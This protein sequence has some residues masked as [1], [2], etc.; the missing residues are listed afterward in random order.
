MISDAYA[1]FIEVVASVVVQTAARQLLARIRVRKMRESQL[2]ESQKQRN[3]EY[4]QPQSLSS[5][6]PTRQGKPPNADRDM[7]KLM[8]DLAAI[9]IQAA[10][11]GWWAR[12]CITVDN[13]CACIIQKN[14]RTHRCWE[15]YLLNCYRIVKVQSVVRRKLAHDRA[16]TLLYCIVVIQAAFRGYF[17]RKRMGPQRSRILSPDKA[18]T[19]I[20][21]QWRSFSSEMNFLRSYE[22]VLVVQSIARGWIT[23]RL[24]RS[25]LKA[26]NIQTSS[27]LLGQ[28]THLQR[29][30]SYS[31][32]LPRSFSNHTEFIR[33]RLPV[34]GRPPH[35]EEPAG[36]QKVGGAAADSTESTA[37]TENSSHQDGVTSRAARTF[38]ESRRREKELAKKAILEEEKRRESEAA[39]HAFEMKERRRRMGKKAQERNSF[40]EEFDR[41]KSTVHTNS[42][43]SQPNKSGAVVQREQKDPQPAGERMNSKLKSNSPMQVSSRTPGASRVLA[44][45][46]DRGKS[47]SFDQQNLDQ[48]TPAR[49]W[50]TSQNARPNQTAGRTNQTNGLRPSSSW[51][52]RT[53]SWK[54]TKAGSDDST[55]AA[56][57][58]EEHI[59]KEDLA[60]SIADDISVSQRKERIMNSLGLGVEQSFDDGSSA[61]SEEGEAS[62]HVQSNP[63]K[64]STNF[65]F[66]AAS[67]ETNRGHELSDANAD[68]RPFIKPQAATSHLARQAPKRQPKPAPKSLETSEVEIVAPT[69]QSTIALR[70]ALRGKRNDS[71]QRRVDEMHAI[72]LRVGLMGGGRRIS[73]KCISASETT[74]NEANNKDS[75]A[76]Q[77]QKGKF[78][79][80]D[81]AEP[82]ASDLI[83]A[84]RNRDQTQPKMLGKLF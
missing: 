57:A 66:A 56:Q 44:G 24:I 9:R 21:S 1:E 18:A 61:S 58:K 51:D 79:Q 33:N 42:A 70:I 52:E 16:G 67:D 59:P 38:I 29:S 77:G 81:A 64:G 30:S 32:D 7:S 15:T 19:I 27:R 37:P 35:A 71:E 62:S 45:W 39:A 40:D 41:R 34:S 11:R 14:Y 53:P 5:A 2:G 4:R 72:F 47:N 63:S 6:P 50:K 23:R 80:A 28:P 26:H 54:V 65:N 60:S 78:L 8:F 68:K 48:K 55:K 73:K 25:W 84:W 82:S 20:Q 36:N 17:V 74:H 83:R 3:A 69:T 75:M 13:Y 22:D 43:E 10:F 31:Y 76:P 49:Q 12:D 46:R